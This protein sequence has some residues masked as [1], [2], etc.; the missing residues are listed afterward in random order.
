GY[1]DARHADGLI[2]RGRSATLD[3]VAR[4]QERNG[5]TVDRVLGGPNSKTRRK[6]ALP[7]AM[8]RAA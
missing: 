8:L 7:A 2:G 4:F 6:L 5:L 3:A 1:L